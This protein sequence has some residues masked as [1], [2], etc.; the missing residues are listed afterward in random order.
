MNQSTRTWQRTA[1][2]VPAVVVSLSVII[3]V[4]LWPQWSSYR[5][6]IVP[7]VTLQAGEAVAIDGRTWQI[8]SVRRGDARS[9]PAASALPK[10]TS[11]AVI[12]L[13]RSGAD[14]EQG[15]SAMLTDGRRRWSPDLANSV[16]LVA[17][18]TGLCGLPGPLQSTF[19]VP[20]G[21]TLEALDIMAPDGRIELRLLL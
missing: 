18:A 11:L 19:V 10:G 17:G 13:T 8:A 12:T 21:T 15:C 5:N 9:A 4:Q 20:V 16:P 2:G 1:I 6:T 7:S 14:P 3:A